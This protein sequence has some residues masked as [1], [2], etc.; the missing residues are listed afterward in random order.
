[1]SGFDTC[2]IRSWGPSGEPVAR[3][4]T[5]LLDELLDVTVERPALEQLQVEVGR[6]LENRV[7]PGLTGDDRKERYLHAVD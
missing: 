3:L 2:L 5:A 6:T 1:M 7:Q 4:G